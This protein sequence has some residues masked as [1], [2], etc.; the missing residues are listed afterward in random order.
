[1]EEVK[2]VVTVLGAV[3]SPNFE[4]RYVKRFVEILNEKI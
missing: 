4:D 2:A 3:A 1:M